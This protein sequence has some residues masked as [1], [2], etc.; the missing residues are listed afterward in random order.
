MQP[1]FDPSVLPEG[2]EQIKYSYNGQEISVAKSTV[3]EVLLLYLI[4]PDGSGSFYIYNELKKEYVKLTLSTGEEY[5]VPWLTLL[6]K[7]KAVLQLVYQ[8]DTDTDMDS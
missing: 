4:A 8:G 6:P 2:F 1:I 7:K 3:G 5:Y